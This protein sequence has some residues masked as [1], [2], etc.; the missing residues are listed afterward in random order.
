MLRAIT[1]AKKGGNW[2]RDKKRNGG[3]FR[4]G[5]LVSKAAVGGEAFVQ[6]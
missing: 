2:Q 6:V 4:S 1:I 3:M 5:V